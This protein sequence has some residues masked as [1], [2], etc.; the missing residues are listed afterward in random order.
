MGFA[1]ESDWIA[2]GRVYA[3]NSCFFKLDS[4]SHF[5]EGFE[6]LVIIIMGFFCL[7]SWDA[8]DLKLSWPLTLVLGGLV[9]DHYANLLLLVDERSLSL[10]SSRHKEPSL[11]YSLQ[12]MSI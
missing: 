7:G 5:L 6:A 4:T 3:W 8:T 11:S 9:Q 1:I 10:S 2:C 12:S